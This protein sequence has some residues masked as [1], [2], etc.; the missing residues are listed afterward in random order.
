[1]QQTFCFQ[2]MIIGTNWG[3]IHVLDHQ[4]NKVKEFSPHSNPV[5]MLDMDDNGDYV[6]SCSHDRKVSP[7]SSFL[8]PFVYLFVFLLLFFVLGFRL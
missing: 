5:T 6:A 3:R 8:Y 4:G 7:Q 1:M 2:L